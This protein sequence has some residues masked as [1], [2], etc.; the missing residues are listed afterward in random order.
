MSALFRVTRNPLNEKRLSVVISTTWLTFSDGQSRRTA[1]THREAMLPNNENRLSCVGAN[2]R[3]RP[4]R[5][6]WVVIQRAT[7]MRQSRVT[8]VDLQRRAVT[9]DCPYKMRCNADLA[10][11][12][13][14]M[15]W[16]PP[17]GGVEAEHKNSL[18]LGVEYGF[19]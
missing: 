8:V 15:P 19:Q 9:A 4:Y 18:G 1:P 10:A 13:P 16:T 7:Y 2:R 12:C 3:V 17:P 14:H 6:G 11:R 5:R